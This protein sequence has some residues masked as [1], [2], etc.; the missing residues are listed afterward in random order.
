MDS[1]YSHLFDYYYHRCLVLFR[2]EISELKGTGNDE[3]IWFVGMLLCGISVIR[4][5]CCGI[6]RLLN[7]TRVTDYFLGLSI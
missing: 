1:A 5:Q 7:I 6:I 4:K 2:K 3:P